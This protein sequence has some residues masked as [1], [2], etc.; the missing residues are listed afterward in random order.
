MHHHALPLVALCLLAALSPVLSCSCVRPASFQKR[1]CRAPTSF[2]GTVLARTDNCRGTCDFLDDQVD[3]EFI[4][5][6]RVD[7]K[8][9]GPR[10]EDDIVYLRT[11]VNSALCGI[12]LRVGTQYM[13]N[14]RRPITREGQC[15]STVFDVIS[16]DYTVTWKSLSRKQQRFAIRNSNTMQSL[17]KRI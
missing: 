8:F 15:P 6:V 3:G 5:I 9:K 12:Q 10:L 7:Q 13:F 14:L 11:A 17:C 2:R 4:F 1:Y 16:C